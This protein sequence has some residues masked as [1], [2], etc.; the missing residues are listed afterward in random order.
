MKKIVCL[1]GGP[2]SGKSTIAAGLFYHLRLDNVTCEINPE[3]I[4]D[5]VW[6]NRLLQPGDQNYA[7]A[8]HAR[9]ERLLI[10]NNVDIII[11]DCPLLLVHFYGIR[12]DTYEQNFNTS[13]FML[14]QHHEFC[15]ANGYK[16]EH[17]FINRDSTYVQEGRWHS[18]EESV[19]IDNEIK[20]MLD[21]F[22]IKYYNISKDK[23][24]VHS[25]IDKLR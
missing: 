13:K 18:Y 17:F 2:C 5:W 15:K 16:C 19:E 10:K 11:N 21:D 3:Y 22:K 9:K 8:K 4:K 1:Y 25:I 6:E 12:H 23:R 24:A 7:F 20:N 14:S